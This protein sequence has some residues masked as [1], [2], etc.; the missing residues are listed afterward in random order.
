[1]SERNLGQLLDRAVEHAPT[2]GLTR[3]LGGEQM[4]A[5]GKRRVRQRRT[6]AAGTGIGALALAAAVW[7]SVS[8]SGLLSGPDT[9]PAGQTTTTTTTSTITTGPVAKDRTIYLRG[10][11]GDYMFSDGYTRLGQITLQLQA[12]GSST[13]EIEVNG[14]SAVV[15]GEKVLAGQI[16]AYRG[17]QVTILTV[18]LPDDQVRRASMLGTGEAISDLYADGDRPMQWWAVLNGPDPSPEAGPPTDVLFTW[19]DRAEAL[20]GAP[21]DF[22][23]VEER[24]L[25]A[26]SIPS[27]GQWGMASH[28]FVSS[29]PGQLLMTGEEEQMTW[30]ARVPQEARSV[31]LAAPGSDDEVARADWFVT[32]GDQVIAGG[33]SSWQVVEGAEVRWADEAGTVSALAGGTVEALGDFAGLTFE[34]TPELEVTASY[35]GEELVPSPSSLTSGDVYPYPGVDGADLVVLPVG[36]GDDSVLMTLEPNGGRYLPAVGSIVD[37]TTLQTESGALRLLKVPSGTFGEEDGHLL[38]IHHPSTVGAYNTWSL[39]GGSVV[40]GSMALDPGLALDLLPG[41]GW[42]I[43][44]GGDLGDGTELL[45]GAIDE[46]VLEW[47]HPDDPQRVVLVAVLTA[48]TDAAVVLPDGFEL[49]GTQTH[50]GPVEGYEVFTA[51]VDRPVDGGTGDFGLDTDGDGALDLEVAPALP[52]GEMD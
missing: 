31:W 35:Q 8:G 30:A 4:L 1:M 51:T 15:D 36:I 34:V 44:P 41:Q 9:S 42:L 38:A 18:P 26:W 5:A 20:S 14:T 29:T 22:A 12:D 28:D 2:G 32:V 23:A 46:T 10:A 25:L 50:E 16:T 19:A 47:V 33:E 43:Y 48:G 27:L 17:E 37:S 6:V 24:G 40:T 3:D 13:A 49:V 45:G 11:D 21:V 7:T 52:W 39:M